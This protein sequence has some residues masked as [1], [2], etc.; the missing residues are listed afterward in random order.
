MTAVINFMSTSLSGLIRRLGVLAA[1]ETNVFVVGLAP[2]TKPAPEAGASFAADSSAGSDEHP[3]PTTNRAHSAR[4]DGAPDTDDQRVASTL[5]Q[6]GDSNGTCQLGS[7]EHAADV[8]GKDVVDRPL[9]RRQVLEG[10]R[11]LRPGAGWRR[12]SGAVHGCNVGASDFG[13]VGAW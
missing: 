6:V 8:V 3:S 2:P 13:D 9:L 11:D 10:A 4:A 7:A 1:V 5:A 12:W